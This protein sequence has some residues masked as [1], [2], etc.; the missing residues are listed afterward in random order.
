M[1][2][3]KF[4]IAERTVQTACR[5]VFSLS[6]A[7]P[8]NILHVSSRLGVS[9]TGSFLNTSK[10]CNVLVYVPKIIKDSSTFSLSFSEICNASTANFLRFA[11]R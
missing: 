5:L 7:Y 9:Y 6:V 8:R 2:I 1:D 10:Y 3:T 11:E 4:L